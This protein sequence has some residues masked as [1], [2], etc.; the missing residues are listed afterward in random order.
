MDG[1]I[2]RSTGDEEHSLVPARCFFG[3]EIGECSVVGEGVDIL[4][5]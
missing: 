2:S 3:D 4:G 5:E 1:H